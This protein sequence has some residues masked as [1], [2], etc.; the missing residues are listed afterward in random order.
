MLTANA[1]DILWFHA[2][3]LAESNK[4]HSY[5]HHA[6]L[7]KTGNMKIPFTNKCTFY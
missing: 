1:H 4:S 7:N 5:H 6:E 2:Y 3:I